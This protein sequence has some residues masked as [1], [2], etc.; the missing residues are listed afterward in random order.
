VGGAIES[1]AVVHVSAPLDPAPSHPASG[2]DVIIVAHN[3][4]GLLREAVGSAAEQAGAEHVWVIDAESTDGSVEAVV[5]AVPGIHMLPVPNAGFAAAN[6]RGF[7]VT[8]QPFVLL[9]NPDAHLRPG[10]LRRL[11]DIMEREPKAGIVGPLVLDPD[12]AVQKASFGR[13]PGFV[14]TVS[15]R[16]RRLFRKPVAPESLVKVDWVTGAAMLVR[17]E[18][19]DEA[20][21]MDEGFFLYYEDVEWCHRMWEHGWRVMLEPAAEVIHH[22]GRCGAS[23]AV[24]SRAYR[25]SFYRYCDMHGL[26]G[27]KAA[28]RAGISMRRIWGGRS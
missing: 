26:R 2:V 17:R 8:E 7:A 9:L 25:D 10:A 22:C 6:N 24:V 5:E 13:F 14:S 27:L 20:G 21:P 15:L 11:I 16:M 12:G 19:I 3:A 18:A 1:A 28:A 23:S 4:G